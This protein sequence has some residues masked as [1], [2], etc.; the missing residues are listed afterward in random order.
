MTF[1]D[2]GFAARVDPSA[3]GGWT[4]DALPAC[5][6]C[7]QR[8]LAANHRKCGRQPRRTAIA[9]ERPQIAAIRSSRQ[10]LCVPTAR[11]PANSRRA[12]LVCLTWQASPPPSYF[13]FARR[14]GEQAARQKLPEL[15]ARLQGLRPARLSALPITPAGLPR[16]GDPERGAAHLTTHCLESP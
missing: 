11:L 4:A 15:P 10:V 1:I 9:A 12:A 16:S 14:T 5:L 13:R 6:R 2:C 8:Q 3:A 7:G